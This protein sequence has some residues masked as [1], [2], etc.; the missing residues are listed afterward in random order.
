MGAGFKF[1]IGSNHFQGINLDPLFT[2]G[3]L[4]FDRLTASKA[5]GTFHSLTVKGFSTGLKYVEVLINTP[6]SSPVVGVAN[7]SLSGSLAIG[8]DSNGW[9]FIT[10]LGTGSKLNNDVFTAYGSSY[11]VGDI[12]GVALDMT[13]GFIYFAKNG[14]WLN[15]G[16]PTSGASGTG[17]A[18][19]GLSGTLYFGIGSY[20]GIAGSETINTGGS[21]FSFTPPAGYSGF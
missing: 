4:S 6:G 16:V 21:S 18:F 19:G 11:T 3:T 12:I 20:N 8:Q 15:S 5:G 7:H 2:V 14:T 9:S 10:T 13:N 1:K 17:A